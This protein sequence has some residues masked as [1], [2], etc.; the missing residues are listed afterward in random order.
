MI[1]IYI[2]LLGIFF[3]NSHLKAQ[4]VAINTTNPDQSAYLDISGTSKG[5]LPPRLSTLDRL[6]LDAM[7]EIYGPANGL[8]I[9]NTD[10]DALQV[11]KGTKTVP[12]WVSLGKS[13]DSGI[14]PIP[15]T[16]EKWI[17]FPVV[18]LEM[19]LTSSSAANTKNLYDLYLEN[20][21]T[22]LG[23]TYTQDKLTFVVLDYDKSCF[24]NPPLVIQ[25]DNSSYFDTLLYMPNPAMVT[26]SSYINI[27]I[28]ITE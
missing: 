24:R 21:A 17:Y 5:L 16:K 4:Q 19:F 20:L 10:D 1:K 27:A 3:F 18:P 7:G 23:L 8:V 6:N 11:N 26:D 22:P 12:N 15:T 2:C 28:K 13:T 9:Y 14:T 25:P